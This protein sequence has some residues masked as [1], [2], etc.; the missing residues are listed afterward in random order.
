MNAK[1]SGST[2]RAATEPRPVVLTAAQR[3][4]IGAEG[5][6][7]V[8]A[9]AG[10]G[11]TT[12]V[13]QLLLHALGV[14]VGTGDACIEGASPALTLERVAAITFTNAAAADLKRKLREALRSAGRADLATDVDA[15]RIG[16][17]HSF[18][19]D[20][21]R[22]FALRAQLPPAQRILNDAEAR[23]LG[24]E[25]ARD[26]VHEAL[27][28]GEL[29][30]L[31]LLLKGRRLGDVIAWV[32]K[33]ATDVDRLERWSDTRAVR[34][35]RPHELALQTLAWQAVTRRYDRLEALGA[36]DFDGVIVSA[37]DL[38]RD[39]AVRHAV[40]RRLRLLVIDE[41]QDV[42]PAQQEI[43]MLLGGLEE[44]D[45]ERT[46]LVLVGDP[47]Q[48][49]YRFR[50][51]DVTLWGRTA[52]RFAAGAGQ[53]LPLNDNFRSKAAI[54]G[55]VDHVIGTLLDRP[56]EVDGV[57][58]P[59]EVDFTPLVPRAG[60]HEG[61]EAVELFL[62]P[63]GPKGKPLSA[64]PVRER[65]L[66]AI[67]ARLTELHAAGHAWADMA[68]L[69][70]TWSAAD[71]LQDALRS[72]GIP[73]YVPRG[74][75]FWETREVLDCVLALRA[76]RDAAD[77]TAV[78]GVLKGPL[79]G[80]RDDTLLRVARA[81]RAAAAVSAPVDAARRGAWGD[82]TLVDTC[83]RLA[84]DSTLDP[85]E[86]SLLARA[87]DLITRYGA[88]RDRLA[89]AALLQR[90][91]LETGYLAALALDADGAQRLANV[92]KLLRLSDAAR[93]Q[94]LGEFLREV[95]DARV[96]EDEIA[97][98][99]LYGERGNVVTITTVHS[100]K[101][102]E[103]DVVVLADL[104]GQLQD[105]RE[106]FIPG[107]ESFVI[108]DV[109][110]DPDSKEKDERH[111]AMKQQ[112]G[113]EQLAERL[114]NWY[115]GATR[116]KRR[117]LLFTLPLG[118][119]NKPTSAAA[120]FLTVLGT[121]SP[122]EPGEP[123]RYRSRAGDEFRAT[124]RLAEATAPV[125]AMEARAEP[126]LA[127]PPTRIP[128]PLGAYRLSASQLM[129]FAKDPTAWR[130]AYV[131]RVPT[132]SDDV[133]VGGVGATQAS[134]VTGASVTAQVTRAGIQRAI[135]TGQIV[136]EVLERLADDDVD[137][138]ALLEEAIGTWDED[139]PAAASDVGAAL[140][141]FVR[142]RVETVRAA[143]AWRDVAAMP[144][145]ARELEF[146]HL[147]DDGTA[148]VGALDLVALSDGRAEIVD[149]KSSEAE[150]ETLAARYAVQGAVYAGAVRAISGAR[151]VR[152]RLV[153]A[154]T[155]AATDVTT[156]DEPSSSVAALVSS[157]RATA[158]D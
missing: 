67:A 4:I 16:T 38:L 72:A 86:R 10:S 2:P 81:R 111:E 116:A 51:A 65:E 46:R 50:R 25:A 26:V 70:P 144:G 133:A 88:L 87:A 6:L 154:A 114:R 137:V 101:G 29:P 32:A 122:L 85:T 97:P 123:Y 42:D 139:A 94:S 44:E 69:I 92:R 112:E 131:D 64:N 31:P 153:S 66:P 37:R 35:L 129:S 62:L 15:A 36:L 78:I 149:V 53:V 24:T 13:V 100:A 104:A 143:P 151:D 71:G 52:E 55:F 135:V 147:L 21:L 155:G 63:P 99:R 156:G 20:L 136:H 79:V 110:E 120:H 75:G 96:R 148:I 132:R 118:E 84:T 103:W 54:L 90:L 27:A 28:T 17:I 95:R 49:I 106:A 45:A 60:H 98:E 158:S 126:L 58:R 22:A 34:A 56:L 5:H 74:K 1:S 9:G 43:A 3:A 83:A 82:E 117:L 30:Q 33:A 23:T 145:A 130:R 108:R 157:L 91:L 59:Y 61:D 48:S 115:V 73:S 142:A 19:G 14:P 134:G 109:P 39:P 93:D 113:S 105:P 102:L 152:F 18:C 107:R 128:A 80:V 150:G 138:D 127:L 57:R 40:Q 12:T 140:R 11:K 8:D 125:A 121:E 119:R 89:T 141:A 68:I 41:F 47:K 7:L 77:D 76:V 124:V 146:T